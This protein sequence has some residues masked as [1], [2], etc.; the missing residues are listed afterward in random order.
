EP[1][2]PVE[3]GR[4]WAAALQLFVEELKPVLD[5]AEQEGVLLLIEPEPGLLIETADQFEELMGRLDSPAVGLNFDVGHFFCVGDE[6]DPTIRRL[7]RW[8]RHFHLEDI[9]ATRVHHHLVPGEGAIDFSAVFN[10]IRAIGYDGWVTIELY[11]YVDDPD[12]AARAAW[13]R[14]TPLLV[15]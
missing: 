5:H 1:G 12:S 11:P 3:P 13:Q 15:S 14:I 6:P 2:G 9:A 7:A 4:P 10:A 8:I